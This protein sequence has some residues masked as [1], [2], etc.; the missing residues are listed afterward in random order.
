VLKGIT[1]LFLARLPAEEPPSGPLERLPDE[2]RRK[3]P[4]Y[5][6]PILT[7]KTGNS[8]NEEPPGSGKNYKSPEAKTNRQKAKCAST[9][10]TKNGEKATRILFEASR[11]AARKQSGPGNFGERGKIHGKHWRFL[12]NGKGG[13]QKNACF[14]GEN[15]S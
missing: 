12:K 1:S 7:Q 5:N 4:A 9:D 13:S 15:G 14:F 2:K 8:K 3:Q 10:S 6:T 11:R